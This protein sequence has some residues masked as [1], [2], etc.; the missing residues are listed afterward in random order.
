[1][2]ITEE[3]TLSTLPYYIYIFTLSYRSCGGSISVFTDINKEG[4]K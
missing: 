4:Y 1:M 3:E 2:N